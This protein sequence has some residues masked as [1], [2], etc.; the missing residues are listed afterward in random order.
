MPHAVSTRPPHAREH[1]VPRAPS[2]Q[3]SVRQWVLTV[4]A[5]LVFAAALL[6]LGLDGLIPFGLLVAFGLGSGDVDP[7]GRSCSPDAT[8]PSSR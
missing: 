6:D 5:V 4:V 2:R 1:L 3:S 8:S 7:G